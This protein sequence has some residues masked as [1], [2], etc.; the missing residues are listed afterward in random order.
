MTCNLRGRYVGIVLQQS[1]VALHLC[2]VEA[3][4]QL[5][6]GS[7]TRIPAIKATQTTTE[8]NLGAEIA[9]D[10]KFNCRT[11]F[12]QTHQSN[13]PYWVAHLD[14]IHFIKYVSI[15][16]AEHDLGFRLDNY[17][18]RVGMNPDPWQNPTCAVEK[19]Q[20]QFKYSQVVQC[21]LFGKYYAIL[22]REAKDILQLCE[23]TA[24][25]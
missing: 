23:V 8:G 11:S 24:Y 5:N 13:D 20:Q 7:N 4:T 21:N 19:N 10:G 1:N 16:N 18:V 25:E 3:Y 14:G 22:V 2:E 15:Y 6:K 12:T 9:I 17:E